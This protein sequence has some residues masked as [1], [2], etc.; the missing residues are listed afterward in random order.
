MRADAGF[1]QEGLLAF[2]EARGLGYLVVARMTPQIKSYC[3]QVLYLSLSWGG[4]ETRNPL[5]E[6]ILRWQKP[7]SERLA[8]RHSMT[9]FSG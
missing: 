4:L 8:S 6:A 2:L 9:S 1:F 7:T 3:R 5:R